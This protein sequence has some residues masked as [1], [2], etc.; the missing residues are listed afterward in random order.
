MAYGVY[1][2]DGYGSEFIST[3]NPYNVID[4]LSVRELGTSG[5]RSYS[6]T[7]GVL[8][9]LPSG[10][11]IASTESPAVGISVSGNTVTWTY[12]STIASIPAGMDYID[13]YSGFI[14]VIRGY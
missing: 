8:Y 5:T 11:P 12:Y 14:Y 7:S 6:L 10:I 9:A 2:V 3:F 13:Q 4:I 1:I